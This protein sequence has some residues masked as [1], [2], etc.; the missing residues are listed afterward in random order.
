M[1]TVLVGDGFYHEVRRDVYKR[2]AVERILRGGEG[3]G[4]VCFVKN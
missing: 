1:N 3:G 2:Q 4:T